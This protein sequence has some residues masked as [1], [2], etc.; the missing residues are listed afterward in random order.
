MKRSVAVIT[1]LLSVFSAASHAEKTQLDALTL[2]YPPYS[3]SAADGKITGIVYDISTEAFS[4]IGVTLQTRIKPWK[5]ALVEARVGEVDVLFNALHTPERA[6]YLTYVDFSVMDEEVVLIAQKQKQ[7]KFTGKLSDISGSQVAVPRGFS[8]G[9]KVDDAFERG[10]LN[11][12]LA[13][14]SAEALRV[15]A[16]G[17]ADYVATDRWTAAFVIAGQPSLT[18]LQILDPSIEVTPTYIV[19]TK[20]RDYSD[21]ADR[22][23]K[24]L[25]EMKREGRIQAILNKY[26]AGGTLQ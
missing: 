21:M 13:N 20:A 2:D 15:L 6:A 17:R 26:V 22:L 8:L 4:R 7:G 5:R 23:A 18:G 19:F 1:V 9:P 14:T 12:V 10:I 3:F 16:A 11:R 25:I 24:T